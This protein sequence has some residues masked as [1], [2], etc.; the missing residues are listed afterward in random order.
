MAAAVS[1]YESCT[2]DWTKFTRPGELAW[3]FVV[4]V[5]EQQAID[6]GRNMIFA[7]LYGSPLL[8]S[9]IVDDT[10]SSA[11]KN[12]SMPRTKS[13]VL[14]LSTGIAITALPCSQRVGRGYPIAFV[15]FDEMAWFARESKDESTDWGIY[16]SII[17]RQLQFKEA[18]KRLIITTPADESGLVYEKWKH[19]KKNKDLYYCVKVPTWRMRPDIERSYFDEQ[20]RLSPDGFVREF[21]AEFHNSLDYLLR[22]VD[23]EAVVRNENNQIPPAKDKNYVM[24][25]DAAFGDRDRFAIA[26]GHVEEEG[27]FGV[28]YSTDKEREET[29]GEGEKE[30]N[31]KVIID[32]AE[33]V[34]ESAGLD[35]VE[36]AVLRVAELYKQY[37]IFEV[38]SDDHQKQSFGK[39][40]EHKGVELTAEAWTAKK[41]RLNYGCLRTLIKQ[42]KVD[43]PNNSDLIEELCGLQVKFTAG[44]QYTVSHRPG[45]NDDLADAVSEVVTKLVDEYMVSDVGA[46]F[47]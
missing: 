25:I 39:L 40:L 2:V 5:R 11:D 3:G 44:G 9:L 4:S 36:T 47:F 41:H 12:H 13:G 27:D 45:G 7:M 23:V 42:K 21:A 20:R 24:A 10:N 6:I 29:A 15:V 17:P 31:F 37:D 30:Y 43:L 33:I 28:Q 26:V 1:C 35:L 14:V 22:R 18:A 8:S 32:V 16:N 34:E 19:R 38:F 46:N